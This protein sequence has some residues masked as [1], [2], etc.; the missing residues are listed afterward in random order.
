MG[1]MEGESAVRAIHGPTIDK[2]KAVGGELDPDT[3][4]KVDETLATYEQ[5]LDARYAAA[6]GYVDAVITPEQT[7]EALT[8]S[9]LAAINNPGPHIGPFALPG[10]LE[11]F[12]KS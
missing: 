1:V 9:L 2:A 10:A 5:Q 6:R 11:T 4:A 3:Q 7:R 12:L 8:L